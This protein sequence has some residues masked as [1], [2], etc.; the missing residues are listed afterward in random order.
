MQGKHDPQEKISREFATRLEHLSPRDKV[1][2]VVLLNTPNGANKT[3]TRRLSRAE[4]KAAAE[5]RRKSAEHALPDI[6][7]IIQ[8]F[9]GQRLEPRPSALG[10]VHVETTP[11]GVKALAASKHVKAVLEDQRVSLTT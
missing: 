6:D 5:A 4:R 8:E 2:A 10:S 7:K 3:A 9:G 11:A 1:R